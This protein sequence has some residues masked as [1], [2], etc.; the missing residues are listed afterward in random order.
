MEGCASAANAV[1]VVQSDAN[2]HRCW[3]CDCN[4]YRPSRRPRFAKNVREPISRWRPGKLKI[5]SES[6]ASRFAL[7]GMCPQTTMGLAVS[8]PGFTHGL[9]ALVVF[10]CCA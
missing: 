1:S 2:D 8:P 5:Y 10:G 3:S 9:G 6:R 7:P 4:Y